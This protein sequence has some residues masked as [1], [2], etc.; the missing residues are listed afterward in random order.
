MAIILAIETSTKSCSVCISKNGKSVALSEINGNYSHAENIALFTQNVLTKAKLSVNDVDAVA[1]SSGPG[2]YTG[3]RIGLSFAKGL[4]YSLS[5]PLISIDTLEA[6]SY[7]EKV[8]TLAKNTHDLPVLLC[9]M[10]DARRME[11][12][13]A[14]F[15]ANYQRIRETNA[16]IIESSSY[17]QF[18]EKHKMLFFGDGAA[19]CKPILTHQHAI[20]IDDVVASSMNMCALAEKKFN[21][22][23]FE[24]TAYFEPNYLK[25]FQTGIRK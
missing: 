14:I 3:L 21:D 9:P 22:S 25:E 19:K 11:V 5:I 10:I 8:N 24:D 12:Y 15:T 2:S 18:L 1:V 13:A 23:L 17:L 6:L 7:S 4:C 16:D 20:F